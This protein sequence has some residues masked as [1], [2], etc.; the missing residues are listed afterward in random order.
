MKIVNRTV[1][2]ALIVS[3][4]GLGM[5][6]SSMAGIVATDEA[7]AGLKRDQVTSFLE[8]SEVRDRMQALGVDPA[9][10]RDRVAALSD[11]EVASLADQLDQLP[12]G[13][14]DVLTAVVVVFLILVILDL[15]G[16]THI[17]PF[18]KS[19]RN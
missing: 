18:T 15:L 2:C 14:S 6:S 19:M 16:V 4:I 12:A 5:P 8:R 13:G 3:I 7:R 11:D 10:A 1:A 9:A 17:F